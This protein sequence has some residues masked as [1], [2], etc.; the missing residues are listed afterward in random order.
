MDENLDEEKF[1]LLEAS[2]YYVMFGKVNLFISDKLTED[3]LF[4]LDLKSEI[5]K[6]GSFKSK[7]KQYRKS[8]WK[9][10]LKN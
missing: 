5:I 6:Q 7:R 2:N 9:K 1:I 10:H 8:L 3:C 4:L